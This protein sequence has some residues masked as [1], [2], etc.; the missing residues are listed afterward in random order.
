[1]IVNVD[2]SRSH[3]RF[4]SEL[5]DLSDS[6]L[7]VLAQLR[8]EVHGVRTHA[9]RTLFSGDGGGATDDVRR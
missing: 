2:E 3:R 6:E 7:I 5:K 1:M 8:S 4:E 9:R